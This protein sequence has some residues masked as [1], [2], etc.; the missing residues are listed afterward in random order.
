MFHH[1]T[2]RDV[3]RESGFH[4]TTVGL[5]L[6]GDPRILPA[7]ADSIRKAAQKIGYA[8]DAM[9]SALSAY[10]HTKRDRFV[11]AIG[12]LHTFEL[13]H[14]YETD[15][16]ARVMFGGATARARELGFK[17]EPI[18]IRGSGLTGPRLN[19]ILKARGIRGLI[20][21][22]LFPHPGHFMELDWA[23]FVTV[24]IGYSILTP[25]SHRTAF[26][27]AASMKLL[28]RELRRLNYR[29]IGLQLYQEIDA[30]TNGNFLGA[31]LADQ[32]RQP[33][34][35]SLPPLFTT[36][37]SPESLRAWI[38]VH[39]PDCII[40][41]S[42]GTVAL[43]RSLG[44]KVPEDIGLAILSRDTVD[45][46]IAGIDEQAPLLGAS[47]VDFVVSLL[48]TNQHG[49]PAYPRIVLVE[50]RWVWAPTVRH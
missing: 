40:T 10:R 6:R 9:L 45:S 47:A 44:F 11:G 19:G 36:D 17:L 48:Q 1:P 28:L 25:Q 26:N 32:L 35:D 14:D 5:A 3:A 39:R 42:P 43:V 29:R 37:L 27:Q 50:G 31:Y 7:T 46:P 23:Q 38:G 16:R 8:P 33:A 20:L 2:L 13:P 15:Q 21:P 4:F 49:L 22:P 41:A 12:Y 30:R 34:T 24:A 18:S